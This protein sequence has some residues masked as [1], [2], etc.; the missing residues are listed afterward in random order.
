MNTLSDDPAT[1]PTQADRARIWWWSGAAALAIIALVVAILG[2]DHGGG[3]TLRAMTASQSMPEDQARRVADNTARV[4][5]RERNMQHLENLENLS[6]P[7][8]HDGVLAR[9]LSL[10]REHKTTRAHQVTATSHFTRHGATWTLYVHDPDNGSMFTMRI[11]NGELR[12][13]QIEAAPIP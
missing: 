10:V 5:M 12:V 2:R 6:C 1:G 9:E 13:C 11:L 8:T 4:W 7:D 3:A